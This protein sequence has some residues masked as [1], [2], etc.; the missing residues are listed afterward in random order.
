MSDRA[1]IKIFCH[2]IEHCY[3]NTVIVIP[4]LNILRF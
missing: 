4:L 3:T 1:L 2:Y